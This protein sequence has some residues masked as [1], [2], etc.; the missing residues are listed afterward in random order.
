MLVFGSFIIVLIRAQYILEMFKR[1]AIN[2]HNNM[3]KRILR[4]K[5]SFFDKNHLGKILTI[6]SKEFVVVD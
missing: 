6:F 5:T 2:I 3:T 1:S 4:A